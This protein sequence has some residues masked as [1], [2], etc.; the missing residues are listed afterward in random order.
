MSVCQ[1]ILCPGEQW[2]SPPHP[3]CLNRKTLLI[4]PLAIQI[5]STRSSS[6]TPLDYLAF[7]QP[8]HFQQLESVGTLNCDKTDYRRNLR[9]SWKAAGDNVNVS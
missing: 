4:Q 6:S 8:I 5:I 2:D 9:H 7:A 3:I 1:R